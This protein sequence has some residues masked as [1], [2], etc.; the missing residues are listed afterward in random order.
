MVRSARVSV[1]S[2]RAR[3]AILAAV[4]GTGCG[5][6]GATSPTPASPTPTPTPDP[7]KVVVLEPAN[8]EALALAPGRTSLVE[9][10]LPT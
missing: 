9:F 3:L 1:W 5:G 4:L 6:G 8:F 10:Q 2:R 7:A